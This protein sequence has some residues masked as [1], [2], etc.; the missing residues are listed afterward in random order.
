MADIITKMQTAATGLVAGPGATGNVAIQQ[1]LATYQQ[2]L[3][4]VAKSASIQ[5]VNLVTGTGGTSNTTIG[6]DQSGAIQLAFASTQIL[7]ADGSAGSLKGSAYASV[8]ANT[9][10]DGS[11]SDDVTAINGFKG[12]LTSGLAAVNAYAARV[13]SFSDTLGVQQDF[14]NK[15]DDIR[16]TALSALVDADM[17]KESAKVSALQVKQQLAFQALSIGNNSTQNILRLFQ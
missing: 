11:A 13:A 9:A 17:E 7:A 6:Q 8:S 5:G 10:F 4:A 3:Q 15:I 16:N 2:Q 14:N 12:A 1:Q